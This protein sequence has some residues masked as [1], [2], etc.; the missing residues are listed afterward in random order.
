MTT[1]LGTLTL[2]GMGTLAA[3]S[4]L[5][6][7][8]RRTGLCGLTLLTVVTSICLGYFFWHVEKPLPLS[9]DR[10][11][12]GIL[13]VAL[14]AD[15]LHRRPNL[16]SLTRADFFLGI[17]VIY[18]LISAVSVFFLT[19]VT[20]GLSR[21]LFFYAFPATLYVA[22]RRFGDAPFAQR[23]ILVLFT[24]LAIYLSLTGL[25]EVFGW[26][27]LV[28]PRYI[29]DTS[30]TDEF[31]GR[32][33]GP[34]LNPV[35]NGFLILIGWTAWTILTVQAPPAR[36]VVFL[37]G[38][39]LFVAAVAST[40]TRSVW[41]S[42]AACIV[43]VGAWMLPSRFRAPWIATALLMLLAAGL[44]AGVY[45]RELKRDRH[46]SAE[47]AARSVQLR[48]LLAA[49]AWRMIQE[50]PIFG[51]GLAQY[52]HAKLAYLEDPTSPL[53]LRQARPYTQH[54]VFL[55][56]LVET[57][58]VGLG[59]LGCFLAA[60]VEVFRRTWGNP[61]R[62]MSILALVAM[63]AYAVNGLFHDVSI[64]LDMNAVLFMMI[65]LAVQESSG[66]IS[67]TAH[68]A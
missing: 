35:G 16:S 13:V 12:W 14:V 6:V 68:S 33:R 49:A 52:D 4:W 9:L 17:F 39:G 60:S 47:E 7:L 36:R 53:P 38:H 26:N 1:E 50:R 32:A 40:L 21:W 54:N 59:L 20:S 18:L 57:G 44:M 30:I 45:F 64:I 28:F 27:A 51:F 15:F 61:S 46:L 43:V 3:G 8:W 29:A 37:L 24:A 58:I 56:L 5:A 19:E 42:A 62:P 67:Q 55:S 25:A 66:E 2:I 22:A 41:L 34:L 63:V 10:I 65:G 11:L 31:F 48:P 23:A